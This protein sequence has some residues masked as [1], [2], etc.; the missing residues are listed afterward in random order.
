MDLGARAAWSAWPPAALLWI[1]GYVGQTAFGGFLVLD[2]FALFFEALFL[3]AAVLVILSATTF[4]DR[5][6]LVEAEFYVMVLF[7]TRRPDA[8]GRRATS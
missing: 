2:G 8:D 1:G 5:E 6:E 7:S 4:A 3:L